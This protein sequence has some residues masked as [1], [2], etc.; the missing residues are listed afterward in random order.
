[1]DP[2]HDGGR[3][4]LAPPADGGASAYKLPGAE[5]GPTGF[6]PVDQHI[7]KPEVT[8][9]EI[10]RGRKVI[11]MPA[12]AP[13]AD[14]EVRLS[15]V[16]APHVRPGYV[17]SADL[18]TR[19][20]EGS[21]FATDLSIRKGGTD[22]ATG[23]RYLEE[24]SFEIVNT[25]SM[26]D[27]REKAED[28]ITRG[29]R[30]VFAIFVKTGNVGE[31]SRDKNDFVMI[32][33]DGMLEDPLLIRPITIRAIIDAGAADDEV[34][35]ALWKKGNPEL[36]KLIEGEQKKGLDEGQRQARQQVLLDLLRERFGDLPSAIQARVDAAD[37]AQISAWTKKLLSA[38]SLDDVFASA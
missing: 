18:I 29:V 36:K 20:S 15:F 13:H 28:L 32:D 4:F 37:I 7:V 16:F 10:I 2:K 24:L 23:S 38:P 33:K 5:R 27:I 11:A 21:N 30:R 25:Q 17:P 14:Q 1:M 34:V 3:I 12:D 22:P 8:R 9:D 26:R 35:R 6:P 19:V 31:W